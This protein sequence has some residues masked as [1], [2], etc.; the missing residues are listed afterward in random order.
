MDGIFG[1][2]GGCGRVVGVA[3]R[4]CAVALVARGPGG[5]VFITDTDR[6]VATAHDLVDQCRTDPVSALGQSHVKK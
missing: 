3:T 2:G 6:A 4:T 5:Y 1:G